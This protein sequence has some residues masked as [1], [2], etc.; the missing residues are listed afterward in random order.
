MWPWATEAS[1]CALKQ[2][3]KSQQSKEEKVK[4]VRQIVKRVRTTWSNKNK[5]L[6]NC[7]CIPGLKQI[8]AWICRIGWENLNLTACFTPAKNHWALQ[9][10][11]LAGRNYFSKNKIKISHLLFHAPVML[12]AHSCMDLV[13]LS[14]EISEVFAP[15][16]GTHHVCWYTWECRVRGLSESL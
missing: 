7:S 16:N 14:Y 9:K 10:L 2:N 4:E 5:L 8:L 1:S 13:Q 3:F 11:Y 12:N 6:Y 15:F